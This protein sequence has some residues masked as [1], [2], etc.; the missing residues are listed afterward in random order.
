MK[1][2]LLTLEKFFEM[3]ADFYL[4]V[5]VIGVGRSHSVGRSRFVTTDRKNDR[6]IAKLFRTVWK[7]RKFSPTAKIFRQIDLQYNSLVKKLI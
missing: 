4:V 6:K 7:F 5:L 2:H 1:Y 3:V